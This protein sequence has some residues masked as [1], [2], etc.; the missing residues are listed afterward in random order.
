MTVSD[1]EVTVQEIPQQY[2]MVA[3]WTKNVTVNSYLHDFL[4]Y[5]YPTYLTRI[6]T[7]GRFRLGF[8]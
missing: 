8:A 5:F 6:V 3:W 7:F 4:R 2:R 1:G